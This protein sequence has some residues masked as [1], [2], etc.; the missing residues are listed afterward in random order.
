MSRK[1]R[2]SARLPFLSGELRRAM[3]FLRDHLPDSDLDCYPF[4]LFLRFA[5]HALALR[6]Q[7][8][9][10][11]ALEWEVFAHYVLFPRVN[12]EDLSFTAGC[13]T[14]RCGPGCGICPAPGSGCWR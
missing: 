11:G 5:R 14:A 10:C 13:S 4:P 6:E 3:E 9:W 1:E 8:P 7:A 12:D 2:W